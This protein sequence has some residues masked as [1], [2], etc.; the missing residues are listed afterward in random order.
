MCFKTVTLALPWTTKREFWADW[1]HN[2]AFTFWK[3]RLK[4]SALK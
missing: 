2:V 4:L 3:M 1:Q